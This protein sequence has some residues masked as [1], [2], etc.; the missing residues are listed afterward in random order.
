MNAQIVLGYYL[1]KYQTLANTLTDI[2]FENLSFLQER[3]AVYNEKGQK[4]L[5]SYYDKNGKEA[6]RIV[7][8]RIVENYLYQGREF[9]DV[10]IGIQKTV[11]YL[12]WAGEIVYSKKKQFYE[13]DLKPVFAAN[14]NKTIIGFSS[15]KQRQ[16]LKS[17]RY[18]TDD[19][20]QENIPELYAMLYSIYNSEYNYYLKTGAKNSLI[21]AMNSEINPEINAALNKISPHEK[22]GTIK[23]FV[24]KNLQ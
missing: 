8:K 16:I 10:F 22:S 24:L 17:E 4:V 2:P 15:K 6:I 1:E 20:L 3:E 21:E 11:H 14:D 7:Y 9:T 12:D 18:N 5:K 19:Y 23:E 13:F